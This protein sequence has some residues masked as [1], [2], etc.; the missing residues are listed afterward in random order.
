MM[1]SA[2]V[3]CMTLSLSYFQGDFL[4]FFFF[5]LSALLSYHQANALPIHHLYSYR[6]YPRVLKTKK[7]KLVCSLAKR[8][9][10]FRLSLNAVVCKTLQHAILQRLQCKGKDKKEENNN[11]TNTLKSLASIC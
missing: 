11:K 9:A 6:S 8:N 5:P 2:H 3:C 10:S 4:C 1:K 7:I